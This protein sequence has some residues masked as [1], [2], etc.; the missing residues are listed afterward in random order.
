MIE[1]TILEYLGNELDVPVLMELPEVPSGDY[2]EWPSEFVII[3]KV[4]S[5]ISN[6]LYRDSIALQSY[7]LSSLYNAASLDEEVRRVIEEIPE[8]TG[9]D[10]AKMQS[11]YNFTD[12]KTKRYRYQSVYD[13]Y[14]VKR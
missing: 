12:T 2:S 8:D 5:S 13:I 3:E 6:R 7:S 4:G 14:H 9:V 11:N 10:A 1:T